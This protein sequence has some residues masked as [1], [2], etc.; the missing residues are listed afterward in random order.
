M[1]GETA[2]ILA[3]VLCLA[4]PPANGA[5]VVAPAS[6]RRAITEPAVV[7]ARSGLAALAQDGRASELAAELDLIAR[8]QRLDAVAREWLLDRGLHQLATLAPTTGARATVIRLARRTPVIYTRVD[9][10]HGDHATPLYDAGATARFVLK[11]WQRAAAREAATADLLAGRTSA[12]DGFAARA[13]A[14][15]ADPVRAGIADAFA[16]APLEQLAGQRAAIT[17]A[18]AA[19]RRVDE[20]ALVLGD[21]LADA[22]LLQLVIGHADAPVAIDAIGVA[23]RRLDAQTAFEL[24]SAAS[25]RAEI[26]SAAMLAMGRLARNVPAARGFAFDALEDPALGPSAAAALAT[27]DDA[28]ITA[29]LGERLRESRNESSRRMLVLALKLDGS[30]AANEELR[31]FTETRAGSRQLQQELRL[32]LER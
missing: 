31:R 25:R 8:D 4:V 20:L 9:P 7:A 12:V 30:A 1:S 6:A 24:L 21:R 26:G 22:G 13:D 19:G 23:A 2:G 5:E 18:I 3:L 11:A 28:S 10:E 29:E 27:I 32:W 15:G 16:G 14:E 17:S